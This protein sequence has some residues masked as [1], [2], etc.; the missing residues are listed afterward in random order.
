MIFSA[1]SVS[2]FVCYAR[3]GAS[4]FPLWDRM[5]L[6]CGYRNNSVNVP[7][8]T[9]FIC[10]SCIRFSVMEPI[11][12]VDAVYDG[13]V[14]N[15]ARFVSHDVPVVNVIFSVSTRASPCPSH[16]CCLNF[17]IMNTQFLLKLRVHDLEII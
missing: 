7:L 1:F 11:T 15:H 3:L 12:N 14:G 13:R 10:A 5:Y 4:S 9:L 8:V 2:W 17:K 6:R 16:P